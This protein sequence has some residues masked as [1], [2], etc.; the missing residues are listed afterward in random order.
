MGR[1]TSELSLFQGRKSKARGERE[2]VI[3]GNFWKWPELVRNGL[4]C[5]NIVYKARKGT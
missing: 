3:L 1:I 5:I 4:T 2:T